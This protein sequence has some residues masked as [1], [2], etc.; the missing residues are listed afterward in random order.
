MILFGVI[1]VMAMTIAVGFLMHYRSQFKREQIKSTELEAR[2]VELDQNLNSAS[3]SRYSQKEMERLSIVAQQTDNAIMIMDAEGNIEWINDGFT[4]MYEYTFEEFIKRRG[5]NIMRTSFNPAIKERLERCKRTKLPVYYEAIN[6]MPS[7][8][9]IWTHT[10]LTPILDENGEIIHLATI[11]SDISKRK[12][13]GDAL[14]E[15]VNALS[16]R[17]NELMVQQKKLIDFTKKLMDEVSNSTS[18]INETDVI[19]SFIRDMSDKIRIM[20]L[21]ASIEAHSAGVLGNGFRVISAEIV[22]MSDET[23]RHAQKIYSIVESIKGTSDNLSDRQAE[24]ED[25]AEEYVSIINNLKSEVKL[26]E[27]V[28]ERLN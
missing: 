23:K 18:K 4:R 20:G 7:G 11:D 21:N 2:L 8:K 26:V 27:Q 25:A 28:A 1:A 14:V 6:V 15:R 9:S 17:I 16:V 5:N 22:K 12:D 10:S 24:V 19:V 13:A 3:S